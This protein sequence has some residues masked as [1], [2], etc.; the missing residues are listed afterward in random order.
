MPKYIVRIAFRSPNVSMQKGGKLEFKEFKE[1]DIV[2]GK[3][4]EHPAVKGLTFI[5]SIIIDGSF[6]IPKTHVQP[7]YSAFVDV[8][9]ADV[10]EQIK[11]NV[12][13]VA[14]G[15]LP[16]STANKMEGYKSGALVGGIIGVAVSLKFDKSMLTCAVIGILAGGYIG[17]LIKKPKVEKISIQKV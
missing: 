16:A 5:P 17:Y 1:G 10:P 2:L 6:I 4:Y 7:Q 12:S 9:K 13:T 14:S 8:N 3:E 11:A 15:N